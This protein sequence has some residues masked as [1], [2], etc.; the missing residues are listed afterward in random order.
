MRKFIKL[1]E[2]LE[3]ITQSQSK[4]IKIQ[5]KNFKLLINQETNMFLC[6]KLEKKKK[7]LVSKTLKISSLVEGLHFSLRTPRSNN[8]VA[9]KSCI[10]SLLALFK[11]LVN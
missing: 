9:T 1:F 3:V 5:R 2:E 10:L 8:S 7:R 11:G 4:I 6:H